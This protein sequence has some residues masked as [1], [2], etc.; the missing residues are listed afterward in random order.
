MTTIYIGESG[1][2]SAEDDLARMVAERSATNPD[3]AL[4]VEAYQHNS[5]LLDALTATRRRLGLSQR[6]VAGRMGTSQAAIDRLEAAEVDPKLS[7]IQRLAVAL[8]GK[9]EWRFVPAQAVPD[10]APSEPVGTDH[11]SE[12]VRQRRVG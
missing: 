10:A 6:A 3:F 8:G 12:T 9:V 11:P 5:D 1:M 2:F 4:L 7:T